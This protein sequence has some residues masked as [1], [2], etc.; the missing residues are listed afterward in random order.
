MKH[1]G[2]APFVH[3]FPRQG[4]AETRVLY[5]SGD[6]F[7]PDDEYGLLESYCVEAG[8]HCR[9]VMINLASRRKGKILASVS[10]A[11]DRDDEFPGPALDPLNPQ[12]RYADVL[13]ELTAQ[14]LDDPVYVD[15]L[16]AH[17]YQVKGAVN[18]PAHPC[19]QKLGGP[20]AWTTQRRARPPRN[21]IQRPRRSR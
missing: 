13:L 1:T 2:L 9:R 14:V 12:S 6:P 18:D 11:F 21:Q 20:V 10:Y 3:I 16:E 7:L 4:A 8:C 17:Y 5:I 19:H 15:R